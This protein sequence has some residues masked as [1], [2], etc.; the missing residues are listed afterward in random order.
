[1]KEASKQKGKRKREGNRLQGRKKA[2]EQRLLQAM[3]NAMG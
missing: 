1:V 2:K 3:H